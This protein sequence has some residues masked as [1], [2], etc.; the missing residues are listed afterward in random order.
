MTYKDDTSDGR[1][2]HLTPRQSRWRAENDVAFV[3][4]AAWHETNGHPLAEILEG[5]CA[6]TWTGG[7]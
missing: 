7:V 5:P 1:L 6:A 4:Q 2:T 3:A